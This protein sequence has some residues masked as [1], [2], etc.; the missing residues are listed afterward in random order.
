[1]YEQTNVATP[2]IATVPITRAYGQRRKCLASGS[3]QTRWCG[4]REDSSARNSAFC[5]AVRLAWPSRIG[6]TPPRQKLN[7]VR[8]HLTALILSCQVGQ[9]T[10]A[11]AMSR[12]ATRAGRRRPANA[13]AAARLGGGLFKA[14]AA[15]GPARRPQG[16]RLP[17]GARRSPG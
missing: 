11:T 16:L 2:G 14:A 7:V 8:P 13:P 1:M 12:T 10:E 15:A 9:E 3:S 5:S 4:G 6:P 17:A